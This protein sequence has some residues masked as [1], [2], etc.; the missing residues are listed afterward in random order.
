[1]DRHNKIQARLII[2]T[3]MIS[4][5]EILISRRMMDNVHNNTVIQKLKLENS[6][7]E[8]GFPS[9]TS[10]AALSSLVVITSLVWPR[11]PCPMSAPSWC[12]LAT[13]QLAPVSSGRGTQIVADRGSRGGDPGSRTT[14]GERKR[15]R[16]GSAEIVN[17]DVTWRQRPITIAPGPSD[18]VNV[19]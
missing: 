7:L 3:N 4:R 10:E 5:K 15:E 11:V 17:P 19:A 12:P 9:L 14:G 18:I 6:K 2:R 13:V 8:T 1:M 16:G